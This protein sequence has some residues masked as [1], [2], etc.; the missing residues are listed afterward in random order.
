MWVNLQYLRTEGR[1]KLIPFQPL[2]KLKLL[3]MDQ[4][5]KIFLVSLML[6]YFINLNAQNSRMEFSHITT[7]E[8]LSYNNVTQILQDSRGFLWISTFNG[9]NRFDGYN[10]KVF[11]PDNSDSGSISSQSISNMLEDRKGFLWVGTTDGL[12]KYNRKTEKFTRYKTD[13]DITT[14]ISN[15]LVYS[16]FEDDSGTIWIGT[17]NGLNKYNRDKDNF[18]VIKK[19]SDRL[20]PD[21]LNSVVSIEED[22]RGNLWLGTWNG[23]TCMQKNGKIIKTYFSQ[24][25]GTK[26]FEYRKISV[27]YRD[28]QNNLWIGMNGKGLI[29]FDPLTSNFTDYNT[30]PANLSTISD[31]FVTAIYQDKSNKL[32]VGTR[33]G[34]NLYDPVKNNFTRIFHD[35]QKSSSIIS[36][37][38]SSIIED[39][40]GIIWIGT[41]AG[42]SRLYYPKNN[43]NYYDDQTLLNNSSLITA[44]L[45][46][47]DNIWVGTMGGLDEIKSSRK[48]SIHFQH[49]PENNNSLCDNFIRSIFVDKSGIV[50]IGTNNDG[51]N[52][53]DPKTGKFQ[54]FTYDMNDT[55]SISNKGVISICQDKLGYLWF[56]TWWGLNR[57]DKTTNKFTGYIYNP[58][59]PYGIRNNC[60]WA[61]YSDSKGM[62]WIGTGGGGVSELDPESLR[63]TNF[64]SDSTGGNYIS[65]NRVFTIFES[66]DGLMWFGTMDGLNC[67]N[68]K[69]GETIV[70]TKKD[71]LPDNLINGIQEDKKGYLWI[72]TG[73]GLSKFN[74]KKIK[75]INY[76][77]RNGID[78]LE[79][80]QNIG[81]RSKDGLL[82]FGSNGLMYFNP[83]SIKD[84]YLTSPV[85]FTDLKIYNK[86]IPISQNGILKES[87]SSIKKISLPPGDDVITLDFALLDFGDVRRN[88]F[89]YKLK[90][91]DIGW[92]SVGNRN[93]ATYTNLPP[94][95]YKFIVKAS[96]NNGVKNEKEASLQIIINPEYYQTW[97]FR[98]IIA[99]GIILTA[100]FLIQG[101]TRKITKQNRML[102]KKVSE[103]TKDL[104]KSIKELS[105]EVLIRKKT[106]E[107]VQASL[108]EKEILLSEK[109]N[110]LSEKEVL[111]KEIHHR[112]KN[113]L[114][115]IS[116][117]LYLNSRKVKD[118]DTLNM[119]KDSQNRVKSI[120]LVHERL[121]RSKDLGNI[122]FREYVI[123][124]TADLFRS[125]AVNQE[126]VKLDININNIFINIDFAVPCGLIINELI[127]NSLKYAFPDQTENGCKGIIKIE[128]NK[129]G[130]GELKLTVSDNGIGLTEQSIERKKLSLGL[131]LVETLVA[132]LDGS[133]EINS[134]S[135]TAFKIVFP[136]FNI[137]KTG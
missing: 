116:S 42:I 63:F 72:A 134:N 112:V 30:D 126:A 56:G 124:L 13:P 22:S 71:G 57:Y 98:I 17:L 14:C 60:I 80:I 40:S 49:D 10:F 136:D 67:Y 118:K 91:F 123:Q 85:V 93:S 104:D 73:N 37:N 9:L 54:L 95:S 41:T 2:F 34:L 87:I 90:G 15:N 33:N 16:I 32:W 135:G 25:P 94:G 101:R 128:F 38:I 59:S 109:E 11:L 27:I 78:N 133:L 12:N 46:S 21:S 92:N 111:L 24:P 68:R 79:F 31:R 125:Y 100:L 99:A 18:S 50:W 115:V 74:R 70:Y 64:T 58:S 75:F 1:L 23:L 122:D 117:L 65:N 129:N 61:L 103:R 69:T 108:K 45:D 55:T 127:T 106:E 110:L 86:S 121:Y 105:Q 44:F 47:Q 97:W 66:S 96:N 39:K 29:K 81:L 5:N 132:Q 26:T 84:E 19:V 36:N 28:R 83:D 77:K 7:E 62:I 3:L 119:F 53:Y 43:F 35:P 131:Q 48:S 89:R 20:N 120:A 102:E 8:G 107:K 88:S 51:L 114:Q 130:N 6:L 52:R 137:N 113:N 76:N 82:Y 4:L